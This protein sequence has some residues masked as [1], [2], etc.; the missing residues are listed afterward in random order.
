VGIADGFSLTQ[1][2][3]SPGENHGVLGVANLPDGTPVATDYYSQHLLKLN[4]VNGQ[5]PASVLSSVPFG[6]AWGAVSVGGQAYVT[7]TSGAYYKVNNSLGVTPLSVLSGNVPS[8]GL[9]ANQTTGHVLSSANIG[10]IDINPANGEPRS[11]MIARKVADECRPLYLS[12][13]T[14]DRVDNLYQSK[15]ASTQHDRGQQ[16]RQSHIAQHDPTT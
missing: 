5:T 9:W 4:D 11:P 13:V 14:A 1:F 6:S 7:A 16:C 8:L 3:S 2:Y 10:L 15:H 12:A